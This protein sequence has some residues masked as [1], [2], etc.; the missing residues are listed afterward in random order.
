VVDPDIEAPSVL[1]IGGSLTGPFNY[2]PLRRRL[3]ERGAARV[4]IAPIWPMDWLAA[5][6]VGLGTLLTRTG[7]AVRRTWRAGGR[8]PIIVIGHS[9]GGLLAR[10]ATSEV[11]FQGRRTAVAPSIG[12][13]VTL[14]TPHRLGATTTAWPAHPG[15]RA[16]AFLERHVPGTAFAPQT[17][18]LTVGSSFVA[19]TPDRGPAIPPLGQ[20]AAGR[21]LREARTALLGAWDRPSPGDGIVPEPAVHLRGARQLSFDDVLH[22]HIGGPWYADDAI[23]DRWWPVALE[24]WRDAIRARAGAPPDT[25]G[26]GPFARNDPSG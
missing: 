24:V 22:G 3:I 20:R 19:P 4:D 18:Y 5:G 13:I 15:H 8:R 17:G 12:A 26:V 14:G 1:I 11:A 21:V 2:W 6:F 25:E 7:L 16:A 9:A 10:L 23:V